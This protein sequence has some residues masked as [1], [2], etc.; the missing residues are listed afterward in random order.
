MPPKPLSDQG[1][2][3]RDQWLD[4][5]VSVTLPRRTWITVAGA[6]RDFDTRIP[7]EQGDGGTCLDTIWDAVGRNPPASDEREAR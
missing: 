1:K 7:Y 2:S 3:A 6:A 4:E 5:P